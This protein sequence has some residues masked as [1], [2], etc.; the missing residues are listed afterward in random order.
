MKPINKA[1]RKMRP[2]HFSHVFQI[3]KPPT[4]F[5][6]ADHGLISWISVTSYNS[7]SW[8]CIAFLWWTI[9]FLDSIKVFSEDCNMRVGASYPKNTHR[10]FSS[11]LK[12]YTYH[13]LSINNRYHRI[14]P[15]YTYLQMI[16]TCRR[17][18]QLPNFMKCRFLL[19]PDGKQRA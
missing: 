10:L 13:S 16:I 19:S 14:C 17:T 4:V 12:I 18:F 5:A 7:L 3:L 2:A 8:Y 1:E 11:Y 9:Y 15:N 6:V